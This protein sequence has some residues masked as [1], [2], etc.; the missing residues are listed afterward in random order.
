MRSKIIG[1][2]ILT[3]YQAQAILLGNE[4]FRQF[5]FEH[6]N[7]PQKNGKIILPENIHHI[8]L[9]IGLSYSAP[10]SQHWLQQENDLFIFGFEPNPDA[11]QTIKNGAIRKSPQHGEPLDPQHVN[12]DFFLIPCAL[13]SAKEDSIKFY[14]TKNDLGCSSVYEPRT[15][16]IEKVI[17]V[18]IFPLSAFFEIFPF[19]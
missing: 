6:V 18:P 15:F 7:L 2:I 16:E 10:M 17:D 9:D 8:K 12:H 3:L 5:F 11:V 13:G 1:M 19:D 4:A 14:V